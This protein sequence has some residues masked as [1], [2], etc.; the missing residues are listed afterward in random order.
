MI[1]VIE[2]QSANFLF[3]DP[4]AAEVFA[5]SERQWWYEHCPGIGY[6]PIEPVHLNQ[7]HKFRP[8]FENVPL[9]AG[10]GQHKC[11]RI[12]RHVNN[13]WK[14]RDNWWNSDDA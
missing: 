9:K 11:R 1:L 6:V 5:K 8:E 4:G 12:V 3:A 2:T 13:W 7:F 10:P 14:A